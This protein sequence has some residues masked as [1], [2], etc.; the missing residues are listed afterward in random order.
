[1][2]GLNFDR[3]NVGFGGFGVDSEEGDLGDSEGESD[4]V[5]HHY[6]RIADEV[7]VNGPDEGDTENNRR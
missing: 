1:M 2:H 4:D 6:E 3:D 5:G 7:T